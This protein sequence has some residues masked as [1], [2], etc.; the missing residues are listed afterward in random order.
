MPRGQAQ[1]E[2]AL[3]PSRDLEPIVSPALVP[4]C[5]GLIGVLAAGDQILVERV[6]EVARRRPSTPNSRRTFVS[7]S[8]NSSVGSPSA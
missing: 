6:L 1:A 7:L 2:L 3:P 4:C 8:R 5:A